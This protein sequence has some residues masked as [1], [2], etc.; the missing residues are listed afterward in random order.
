MR[1]AFGSR[2]LAPP[3]TASCVDCPNVSAPINHQERENSKGVPQN[4]NH[5]DNK[6]AMGA[7][8]GLSGPSSIIHDAMAKDGGAEGKRS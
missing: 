3:S 4:S 5:Q 6:G 1:P 7:T 2:S 8:S